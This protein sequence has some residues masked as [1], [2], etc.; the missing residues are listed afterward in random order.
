MPD[1]ASISG[2]F[3]RCFA[4]FARDLSTFPGIVFFFPKTTLFAK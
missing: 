3:A 4:Y 1:Y 2:H